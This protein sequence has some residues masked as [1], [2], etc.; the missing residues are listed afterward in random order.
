[1][2]IYLALGVFTIIV[3]IF[4]IFVF[5]FEPNSKSKTN[6]LGTV[7][8][9]SHLSP[10]QFNQALSLGKYKL[11]DVRTLDEYNTG[12]LKNAKQAD[13]Y[14]TQKFSDYLDTLDKKMSYLIYCR[15]GR[16][17]QEALKIMQDKGFISVSDI[18][19]GY[20]AWVTNGLPIEK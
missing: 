19:G 1:M 5:S 16:R 7:S 10:S 12:H 13:F 18:S 17:S 20:N 3:L 4:G 14:Q 6:V 11:I 15:S 9:F 8:A 2:K